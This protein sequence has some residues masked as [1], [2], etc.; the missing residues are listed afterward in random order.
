MLTPYHSAEASS[1]GV[2]TIRPD[3]STL[4]PVWKAR[5]R[6]SAI[7]AAER[8]AAYPSP[9]FQSRNAGRTRGSTKACSPLGGGSC[10]KHDFVGHGPIR[11]AGIEA[12]IP[13]RHEIPDDSFERTGGRVI[14]SPPFGYPLF[15][16]P[17]PSPLPGGLQ[18]ETGIEP[19]SPVNSRNRALN[20]AWPILR[21]GIVLNTSGTPV[22]RFP[23]QQG[24]PRAN[25]VDRSIVVRNR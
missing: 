18:V 20:K 4:A 23:D 8:R 15:E 21:A 1:P 25:S 17:A 10:G 13:P 19:E 3:P 5:S 6:A 9:R 11:G 7:T 14:G 22:C 16:I 2:V 12:M 24:N